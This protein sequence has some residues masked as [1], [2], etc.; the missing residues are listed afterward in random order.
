SK[1]VGDRSSAIRRKL[2][3][4]ATKFL[5]HNKNEIEMLFRKSTGHVLYRTAAYNEGSPF[6]LKQFEEGV[7]IPE[8]FKKLRTAHRFVDCDWTSDNEGSY[9]E[10]LE[11]ASLLDNWNE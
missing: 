3:P 9:S 4:S 7:A 10:F 6:C 1:E 8:G 5:R 11:T 2:D